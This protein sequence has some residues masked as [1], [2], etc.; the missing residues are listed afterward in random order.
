MA[1]WETEVDA[2]IHADEHYLSTQEGRVR[3]AG[4][5][6]KCLLSLCSALLHRLLYAGCVFC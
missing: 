4:K 6:A 5:H 2:K 3:F 1:E